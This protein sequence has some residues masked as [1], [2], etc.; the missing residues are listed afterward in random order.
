MIGSVGIKKFGGGGALARF[1]LWF[2][3]VWTEAGSKRNDSNVKAEAGQTF[4]RF[5]DLSAHQG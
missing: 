1:G 5:V 4:W 3:V 2:Q